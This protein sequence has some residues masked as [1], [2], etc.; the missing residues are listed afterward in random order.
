MKLNIRVSEPAAVT[1]RRT[2]EQ[3]RKVDAGQDVEPLCEIGFEDLPQNS[4]RLLHPSA[5]N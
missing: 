5:G 1:K 4:L 3:A 2:L